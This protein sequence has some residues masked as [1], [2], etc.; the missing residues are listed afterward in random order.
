MYCIK[1]IVRVN[2]C[3]GNEVIMRKILFMILVFLAGISCS[4]AAA[5]DMEPKPIIF[6][7]VEGGKFIYCNSPEAVGADDLADTSNR[8]SKY[9]MNNRVETGKYQ[10][11]VS[12][13][14]HTEVRDENK[15]IVAPGFDIEVD[16]YFEAIEDT[17][18]VITALGFEVPQHIKYYFE[19]NEYTEEETIG[20]MHAW[21]DYLEMPIHELDS[22]EQYIP[23]N[24][25][26]KTVR[27]SAGESF[28]L[29]EVI[30]N[31]CAVPFYRPVHLLADFEVLSG[32][33]EANVAAIRS[34]GL[35]RDRRYVHPNPGFGHYERENQYKGVANSQNKVEVE[36]NYTISD[37]T[38]GEFPVKVINCLVPEGK[39][40][41]KW[42]TN[43]NPL[44]TQWNGDITVSSDV[45]ELNYEDDW[46]LLYYGEDVPQEKRNNVW[47]FSNR[48][49]DYTEYPGAVSGYSKRDYI[50]NDLANEST[51]IDGACNM[52][53]YGVSLIYKFVIK[54]EGMV[55]RYANYNLFTTSNNIVILR[56]EKGNP[57]NDYAICKGPL[58]TRETDTVASV[59]LPGGQTT[60]FYVEIILPPNYYGGMENSLSLSNTRTV[61]KTYS[62]ERQRVVRDLSFTGREFIRWEN[63]KLF[64]SFD[65]ENWTQVNTSP[66]FEKALWGNW[67]QYE[68]LYTDKGYMVK[69][70]L[71]DSKPYYDVR[72]FFRT[73]YFLNDDFSLN[74]S[75]TFAHY[76]TD[77][78]YADRVYYV[79]AGS[80]YSSVD[81][82]KWNLSDGSF[83]LPVWNNYLY[84]NYKTSDG[85]NYFFCDGLG[86]Q[87]GIYEGDMPEFIDVAGDMYYYLDGDTLFAS[88]DG[89]YFDEIFH[90]E[91]IEKVSK[92]GDTL[93][94]NDKAYMCPKYRNLTV[95]VDDEYIIFKQR[96]YTE[97]GISYAPYE[98]LK[99]VTGADVEVP[100][101]GLTVKDGCVF[102]P[103][104]ELCRLNGFEVSYD[105]E[106]H[107]VTIKT[108]NNNV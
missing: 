10:M 37:W 55:T 85:K 70:V 46:K 88:F 64:A 98:F 91:T 50:P 29:S 20:S 19:G 76:P 99:V 102:V 66:E 33:A 40:T 82:E 96:P 59:A 49:T 107:R 17:E 15:K 35:L 51:T 54:N 22:G 31:Y 36:L 67:S 71:Y 100:D 84:T 5:V 30:D 28:W 38:N 95:R 65:K 12:H 23:H 42:V 97:N 25:E 108:A 89:M 34:T 52:G 72:G 1:D 56:D 4:V 27:L 74:T 87:K 26:D 61:I 101:E 21:A 2:L 45:L 3:V 48:H 11:F 78:S 41:N 69:P 81:L 14:N 13:V 47:T 77:M 75:A 44:A 60:T 32:K 79:T 68:F 63:G 86:F 8:H 93:F 106:R 83:N 62:D 80:K 18:I 24:F 90:G 104:A 6:K 57:V 9:L 53:N 94:V 105:G 58:S 7:P 43:L 103:I 73:V 92:I 39:I 16:V